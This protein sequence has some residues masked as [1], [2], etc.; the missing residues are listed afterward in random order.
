MANDERRSKRGLAG[1]VVRSPALREPLVNPHVNAP[2]MAAPV[3]P[4]TVVV[5]VDDSDRR[6]RDNYDWRRGV[7]ARVMIIDIV[8][9]RAGT[10]EQRC[11]TDG[12]EDQ[13][14]HV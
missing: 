7:R 5:V 14:F 6:P 1:F 4:A 13:G 2:V 12:E 11:G 8:L 10:Q 3:I 9:N